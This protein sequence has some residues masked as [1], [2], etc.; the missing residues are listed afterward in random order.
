MM[1][2]IKENTCPMCQSTNST[3]DYEN[4]M[5]CSGQSYRKCNDCQTPF[6]DTYLLDHEDENGV[7]QF[8]QNIKYKL[9]DLA[10]EFDYENPN[11][12]IDY[13]PDLKDS[14]RY[15]LEAEGEESY[16]QDYL[17]GSDILD[18]DEGVLHI[19]D[20]KDLKVYF[21]DGK[22]VKINKRTI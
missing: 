7:N 1:I 14:N 18:A 12:P 5:E 9:E 16:L 21:C 20:L 2:S 4:V 10:L 8:Q 19:I 6:V 17:L 11:S 3:V 13:Y 15:L 22:W